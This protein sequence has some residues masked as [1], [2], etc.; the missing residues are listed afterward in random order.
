[1]IMNEL[2]QVKNRIKECKET[3]NP[4]LCIEKCGITD[5]YELPELLECNHLKTLSLSYNQISDISCLKHLIELESLQLCYNRICNI[6]CLKNLTK[7][8][9]LDLDHNQISDIN[10]LE[11]LTKL[12]SLSLAHNRIFNISSLTNLKS[13]TTLDLS[14][15]NIDDYTWLENLKGIELLNLRGNRI[16]FDFLEKMTG[17]Q[18]LLL[19]ESQFPDYVCLETTDLDEKISIL[20]EMIGIEFLYI[21]I[22]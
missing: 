8:Q 14:Y 5:L 4:D 12:D 13:L 6:S 7:L 18:E 2:T 21:N 20:E 19:D 10:S 15:N 17:L 1:M 9:N 11:Y 22:G 3:K 16:D